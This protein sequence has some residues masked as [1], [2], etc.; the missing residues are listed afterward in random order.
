MAARADLH[1]R[2]RE[3]YPDQ[4]QR[5]DHQETETTTDPLALSVSPDG[6][7]LELRLE[8]G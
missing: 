4:D 7:I 5:C 1:A 8:A 3:L 6:T 2:I